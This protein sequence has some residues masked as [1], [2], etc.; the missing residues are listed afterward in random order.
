M[1]FYYQI[2]VNYR[3]NSLSP[4]TIDIA[5]TVQISDDDLKKNALKYRTHQDKEVV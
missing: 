2:T 5:S 3:D 4:E 1:R